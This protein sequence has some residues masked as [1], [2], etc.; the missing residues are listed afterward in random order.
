MGDQAELGGD[1]DIVA[2]ALARLSDDLFGEGPVDLGG[3]DVGDTEVEGAVDGAD[4]LGVVEAA[5]GGVGAGHGHGAEADA[6]DVEAREVGVLHRMFFWKV[7][8]ERTGR[9]A[10]LLVER[11]ERVDQAVLRRRR[12]T[13]GEFAVR[14]DLDLEAAK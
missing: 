14:V 3:V 2:A 10:P 7:G 13:S 12:R 6:G 9:G 5:F 1:D 8:A 4:R 11:G